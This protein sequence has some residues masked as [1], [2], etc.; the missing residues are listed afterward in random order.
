MK[1]TTKLTRRRFV[2]DRDHRGRGTGDRPASRSRRAQIRAPQ[3]E[4][5][6]GPDRGR[7]PGARE[8]PAT[9][10]L[11]RRAGDRPGRSVHRVELGAVLLQG[12][13]RPPAGEGGDRE[14][15]RPED[16][17]FRAAD[18]EDFREMLDRQK[19]IDAVLVATPDHL[20][21]YV[22]LAAMRQGKHTYCEKP[23]THNL[24]EARL[25]ARV[26]RETGLATQMGNSGHSRDGIRQT[27]EWI[28]AGA[29][30]TVREVHSWCPRSVGTPSSPV[31]QGHAGAPRRAQLGPVAGPAREPAVASGL[32]PRHVARLLA[33]RHGRLRD[34]GCHD[35]DAPCWPSTCTPRRRW[36]PW[37]GHD[38]SGDPAARL[39]VLLPLRRQ[40]AA[41]CR[42]A[43]LV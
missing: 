4:S 34:F 39:P 21:A 29:V 27:C 5:K 37:C 41:A 14:A 26:A 32:R 22:S 7:G 24:R 38:R 18:Y 12:A 28:W 19:A 40:R 9:V 8:P 13:G 16:A 1:T 23:L 11:G 31:C 10:P 25:V 6:R 20:H 36:R 15:L 35:M 42:E 30:G 33:I 17:N 3:R 2:R 43:H